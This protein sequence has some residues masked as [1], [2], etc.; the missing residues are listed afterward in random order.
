MTCGVRMVGVGCPLCV[1]PRFV[2]APCGRGYILLAQFAQKKGTRP[3]VASHRSPRHSRRLPW[4]SPAVRVTVLSAA[5]GSV[6]ALVQAPAGAQPADEPSRS[7]A[8]ARVDSLY[9]DAEAAT[10]RY[11]AVAE[12]A[13]SLRDQVEHLQDRVARGQHRVNRMRDGLAAVAGAQYRSGGVDPALALMLDTDPQNYL[14]RTAVL[15]RIGSRQA[16]G[17]KHLY[18]LVCTPLSSG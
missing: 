16:T 14:D 3:Q 13:G 10:E 12:R 7:S 5:A 15:E 6:A 11:N 2:D 4:Q 17:R 8:A 18:R 9:A 1:A